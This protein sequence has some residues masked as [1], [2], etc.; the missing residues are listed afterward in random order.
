MNIRPPNSTRSAGVLED[1][2]LSAPGSLGST[3][4]IRVA[5]VLPSSPGPRPSGEGDLLRRDDVAR[6]G[7]DLPGVG[8]G[9]RTARS[10]EDLV[11]PPHL[12]L[13][14]LDLQR[15]ERAIE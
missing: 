3:G 1:G 2:R 15:A 4:G 10:R 5:A 12:L 11:E 8:L 13:A 14:E 7:P 6:G 9:C